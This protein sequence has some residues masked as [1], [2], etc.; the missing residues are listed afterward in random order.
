MNQRGAWSN[1]DL[2]EFR[3]LLS[4][5]PEGVTRLV[6][7]VNTSNVASIRLL[8]RTGPTHLSRSEHGVTEATTDISQISPPG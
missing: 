7:S 4:F 8:K 5:R 1:L 2:H 6:T 3:V